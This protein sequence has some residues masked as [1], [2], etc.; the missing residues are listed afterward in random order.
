MAKMRL[1]LKQDFRSIAFSYGF[2]IVLV[3]VLIFFSISTS[4]FLSV[5]NF[6]NLLHNA[7]PMMILASGFA[8][9]V[10]TGKLDISIGSTAYLA[11]AVGTTL[12]VKEGYSPL[13]WVMVVLLVGM[14]CG[15][16]NGI[17]VVYLKVNPLIATMGAM[18]IYRGLGL[19]LTKSLAMSIPADLRRIGNSSIGPLYADFVLALLFLIMLQIVLRYSPFGRNILA[20]GNGEDTARR[21][22]VNVDRVNLSVFVLSGLFASIG[23]ILIVLQVG[24]H[25]AHIGLGLEFTG[26][27]VTILGGVS[28]FGGQGSLVPGFMIGV[29]T[30]SIIENGLNHMGASPYAYPF[31]R[32]GI[33]FVAMFADSMKHRVNVVSKIIVKDAH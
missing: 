3:C 28:L 13:V 2:Y 15:L 33:I 23:G 17:N 29:W 18:F 8:L 25:N 26:M 12:L 27:A 16:I 14:L 32:G 30:L 9:I 21:L 11:T 4:R 6:A 1:N 5:S 24:S 20:I 22:G 19:L 10:M 7:A 31:V